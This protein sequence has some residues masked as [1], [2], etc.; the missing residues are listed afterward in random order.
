MNEHGLVLCPAVS[1]DPPKMTMQDVSTPTRLENNVGATPTAPRQ[2]APLQAP[3]PEQRKSRSDLKV[4]ITMPAYHA[5]STVEKTLADIPREFAQHVILVDDASTDDTVDVAER[6]GLTVVSHTV[7]RGYGGNQKTCYETALREGADIVVMLHP[8]YQYD[9]KAVPLLIGPLL[10]G[11]ADMTFGSR[12][13]GMADPRSGGMPWFRYYGNR[14][15][16]W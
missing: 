8:D 10:T 11:D 15:T 3:A 4:V 14:I 7:N 6:L 12:F 1:E 16:S 5:G 2:A 13:A 9:P